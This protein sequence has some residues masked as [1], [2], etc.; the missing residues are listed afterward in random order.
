MTGPNRGVRA[1]RARGLAQLR[2]ADRA[3]LTYALGRALAVD[4]AD[5]RHRKT[6]TNAATGD[7]VCRFCGTVVDDY[8][9]VRE[10]EEGRRPAG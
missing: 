2:E 10:H 3:A 7:E 6:E 8:Q 1:I 9:D 4:C 5:G